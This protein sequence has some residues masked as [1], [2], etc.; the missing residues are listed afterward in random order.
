[1]P[2]RSIALLLAALA[3]GAALAGC[4]GG[5]D[6]AAPAAVTPEPNETEPEILPTGEECV[7]CQQINVTEEGA[8]G[9]EHVHDYW[10]GQEQVTIYDYDVALSPIPTFERGDNS[11]VF[12]GFVNLESVP[13]E[14]ERPA[15]VYEGAGKVTFTITAGPPWA[16]GYQ[17]TYRTAAQDWTTPQPIVVGEALDYEPGK[18]DT[19]MPH[20]FR[21]LWNWKIQAVSPVPVAGKPVVWGDLPADAGEEPDPVPIHV[22]IVVTKART[23]DDW[24]GHPA[25]YAENAELVVAEDKKGSTSVQHAADVLIYGVEPD[26]IVPDQL[27]SMGTRYV[28]VYVNVTRMELPPGVESSGFY[29]FWRAAD[30]RPNDLGWGQTNNETD[31]KTNAYWRLEVNDSMV[32]SPYQPTSRFSFKVLVMP[33]NDD[34]LYCYRCVPYNLEYTMTVIARPDP[35]AAPVELKD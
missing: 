25:F 32:D 13:D 28:D 15:L 14:T 27:I 30:T 29:L 9:I 34:A 3:S 20:S 4:I 31:G 5:G 23:V 2:S 22:E 16:T 11:K 26:Q 18:K 17:V 19:D 10:R 7:A 6:D 1:M 12:I 8:G 33:A 24:P 21:S 35:A